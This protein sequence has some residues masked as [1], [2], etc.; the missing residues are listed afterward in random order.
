MK[1][2]ITYGIVGNRFGWTYNR[3]QEELLGLGITENDIIISGGA[4]GVDTFAQQFAKTK[5]CTMI[6]H[7]PDYNI[8]L[9][10]RYFI[11]NKQIAEECDVLVAFDK[12]SSKGSGT[13]NTINHARKLGKK[14][15]L[16]VE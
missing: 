10:D 12:G 15:I 7:Y 1:M 3:V 6:I 9:P 4:S 16:F 5:G 8:S 14:V 13:L 2:N 11:R